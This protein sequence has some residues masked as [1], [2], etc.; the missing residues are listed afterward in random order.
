M[1]RVFHKNTTTEVIKNT[2]IIPGFFMRMNSIGHDY[3]DDLLDFSSLPPLVDPS[4][5]DNNNNNTTTNYKTNSSNYII[6]HDIKDTNC[7]PPQ[8]LSSPSKS[9]SQDHY[10]PPF[11][12]NNNNNQHQMVMI[13]PEDSENLIDNSSSPL[14]Q[15]NMFSSDYYFMHQMQ[16]GNDSGSTYNVVSSG[17]D[18]IKQFSATTNNN[19]NSV[20]SVSQD[21]CLSND[22]N[23]TDTSSVVSKHDHEIMGRNIRTVLYEDLELEGPSSSVLGP[24]SNFD[25]CIWDDY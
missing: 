3:D 17:L 15:Q 13:K 8:Q 18:N 2:P 9:P 4:P 11:L 7:N 1:S 20:V 12:I 19:N 21:T 16:L 23:T 24:L 22:R 6:D 10:V 25:Q 14:L 5:Y